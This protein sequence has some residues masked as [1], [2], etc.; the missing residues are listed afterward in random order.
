MQKQCVPCSPYIRMR[1]LYSN[2]QL[3]RPFLVR[4]PLSLA[5]ELQGRLTKFISSHKNV[6]SLIK[7]C[8]VSSVRSCPLVPLTSC[9]E[10]ADLGFSQNINSNGT[11]VTLY[12]DM[13]LVGG[14]EVLFD[15]TCGP[16][17]AYVFERFGGEWIVE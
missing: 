10:S 1:L 5:Y 9:F 11:G 16:G 8:D 15:A 4:Y 17:R 13:L 12:G 14:S 6:A 7:Q 2:L 3:M